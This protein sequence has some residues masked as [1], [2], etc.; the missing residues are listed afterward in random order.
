MIRSTTDAQLSLVFLLHKLQECGAHLFPFRLSSRSNGTGERE[1][2]SGT[3]MSTF[4]SSRLASVIFNLLALDDIPFKQKFCILPF[5][6][7]YDLFRFTLQFLGRYNLKRKIN[8]FTKFLFEQGTL[9]QGINIYKLKINWNNSIFF[10]EK[11]FI[12][13]ISVDHSVFLLPFLKR[14]WNCIENENF[15]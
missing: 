13:S 3:V 10:Q 8:Q 5:R 11:I 15:V 4:L 1:T 12:L 2:G 7:F 6:I 14:H 9:Q